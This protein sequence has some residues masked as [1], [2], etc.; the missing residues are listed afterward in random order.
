[1][2]YGYAKKAFT[3]IELLVVISII[4]LLLSIM[5]PALNKVKE[6]GRK[7]VCQAHLRQYV[8]SNHAYASDNDDNIVPIWWVANEE[9]WSI[10]GVDSE[11]IARMLEAF[12]MFDYRNMTLSDDWVCP[13]ANQR[14]IRNNVAYPFTYAYNLGGQDWNLDADRPVKLSRIRGNAEKILFIDSSDLACNDERWQF[15]EN[16]SLG[17]PS[18]INYRLFWDVVGDF[19]GQ[20]YAGLAPDVVIDR[21]YVGLASYRHS[22]GANLGMVDGHVEFRKKEKVWIFEDDG[23][24]PKY[25]AMAAMWDLLDEQMRKSGSGGGG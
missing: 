24:T 25:R 15:S 11:D 5:M 12:E 10:I 8:L 17:G 2:K 3:L 6:A 18:P 16:G 7:A 19:F 21:W 22:E 20:G 14:N 9:F 13:S 23:W 4:A 1:M